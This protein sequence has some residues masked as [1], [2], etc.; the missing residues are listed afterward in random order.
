MVAMT[1]W[2]APGGVAGSDE[3]QGCSY[4][5]NLNNMASAAGIYYHIWRP[6]EVDIGKA[7]D[8]IEPLSN[9]LNTLR[10]Q[11]DIMKAYNPTNGW[12]SYESLVNLVEN[13]LDACR[14]Y[15]DAT[16]EVCR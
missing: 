2:V 1:G 12:G 16:V 10:T 15:P 9:G 11:Q 13:Y 3:G 6:S 4:C 8:L 5:H 7:Q 14:Q